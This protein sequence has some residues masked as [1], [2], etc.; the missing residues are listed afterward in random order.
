MFS[1]IK[2]FH[3][4]LLHALTAGILL[5]APAGLNAATIS[6]RSPSLV[7]VS[8]AVSLAKDGDT[9]TVPAGSAA[10]SNKLV[11][12]TG[13]TLQGATT[14]D[15]TI[16]GLPTSKPYPGG[17]YSAANDKTIITR[18]N[19]NGGVA[20]VIQAVN[21]KTFRLSGLTF[22]PGTS[23]SGTG[24]LN[25][26]GTATD[27][28]GITGHGVRI[29]NCHF[30]RGHSTDIIHTFGCI[31]GV[32]DHCL[33]D[34]PGTGG[35]MPMLVWHESYVE[36]TAASGATRINGEG[37]WA[38][39]ANWGSFK[40]LFV[41]DCI[42]N[43]SG[44]IDAKRGAR[45]VFRHNRVF[46]GRAITSHGTEEST[47]DNQG[48]ERGVR[49][50][51]CYKNVWYNSVGASATGQMRSG[52]ILFHDNDFFG[53]K[54]NSGCGLTLYREDQAWKG[55][56]GVQGSNPWDKN[57][58]S[59]QSGKF[60]G[61]GN[62]GLYGSGLCAVA[63][64]DGKTAAVMQ[65][66]G[67]PGWAPNQWVGYWLTNLDQAVLQK[68]LPYN[69]GRIISNTA[70]TITTNAVSTPEFQPALIWKVGD[71]FEIRRALFALDQSGRGKCN[72]IHYADGHQ[73]AGNTLG[74]ASIWPNQISEPSFS[75]NNKFNGAISAV[76]NCQSLYPTIRSGGSGAYD[77]TK[78]FYLRAP[79]SGDPANSFPYKE[80]TYPHPLTA[81]I[82]PPADL[83]IV[84]P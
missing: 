8:A 30:I 16:A 28:P 34:L 29:D 27:D 9:V 42:F 39:D 7:D 20:I 50:V 40:F 38:D 70:N 24:I 76:I 26:Q 73:N 54:L 64:G 69:S 53:A 17:G 45:Y 43:G 67:S 6:A 22:A 37:S 71:R 19:L 13:I 59:D 46:D 48:A 49:A 47:A 58:V 35:S 41:E 75:W 52:N 78:S 74:G 63:A 3:L 4:D 51:E 1:R 72:F 12:S 25:I 66:Q 11:I 56:G 55:L 33:L 61:S 62:N 65:A 5:A 18:D 14:V 32:I 15:S 10:W 21:G 44:A 83:Q 23:Q 77:E 68:N 36:P 82:A 31:F 80:Y 57:D 79:Q 84:G 60:F 81:A 2:P